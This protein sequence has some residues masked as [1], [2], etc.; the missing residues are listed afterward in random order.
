VDLIGA[1]KAAPVVDLGI[2]FGLALFAIIGVLQGPIRRL[3]GMVTMLVA[4]LFAANLRDTF[5][6]FL[7]SN[8]HQFDLG[9]NRLLAFAILFFVLTVAASL[10]TQ[11][12]Y[13]RLDV[14]VEHPVV[15]D[16]LGGLAGFVEGIL[17]L[18]LVVIILNSFLLPPPQEGDL[19]QLRSLQDMLLNQSHFAGWL[20]DYVAPIVVHLFAPLLP[21][22]VT[23]V[24]P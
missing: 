4:F 21:V 9:Y 24:Y 17:L 20:N 15:D 22:D 10:A 8:W 7:A 13:H 19:S 6:D 5:G 1:I 3:I 14:S 12:L 11:G 18:V 2:L 23:A 16:V